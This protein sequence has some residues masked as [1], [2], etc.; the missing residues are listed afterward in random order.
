MKKII[1]SQTV[2]FILLLVISGTLAV[3]T[4][5][6]ISQTVTGPQGD[7]G[8]KGDTGPRGAQGLTG[9]T[10]LTGPSGE[11][12]PTGAAGAQGATGTTGLTGA[13]G[14]QGA[15]GTTGLTGANGTQGAKGDIGATGAAGTNGVNGALWLSGSGAPASS[16][17]VDGDYYL[18]T[19]NSDVYNKTSGTWATVI[20]IQGA[21]GATGAMGP[22]GTGVIT[23]LNDTYAQS[24]IPLST[25]YKTV[26]NLSFTA[27]SNGYVVLNVN[28]MA[29]ITGDTTVEGLGLGTTVN[30]YS[31]LSHTIVGLANNAGATS[32]YPINLQSIVPVT[33]GSNY[34]FCANAWI[35]TSLQPTEIYYV[36]MT[37]IFYP[38]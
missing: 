17:G 8:S 1:F 26:S 36:Y 15:T 30:A 37:G 5:G 11:T 21:R 14:T 28:A 13:N 27:P 3:V 22:A 25:D 33:E 7:A 38:A 9:D 32:Y 18:N 6:L 4:S 19:A 34:N 12:G 31:T 20:N 35:I 2:L 24:S 16:L 23:M 29:V 10:G